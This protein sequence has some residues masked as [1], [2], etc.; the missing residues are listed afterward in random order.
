MFTDAVN[1][2]YRC[3]DLPIPRYPVMHGMVPVFTDAVIYL[4]H[5]TQ[6]CTDSV[7]YLAL[8][9]SGRVITDGVT[10]N[11]SHYPGML[12]LLPME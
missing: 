1:D 8:P 9:G 6:Y 4:P 2:V 10:Y 7:I 12:K 3:C 5:V 11:T